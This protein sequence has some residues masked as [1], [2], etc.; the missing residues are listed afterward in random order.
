M[1]VVKVGILDSLKMLNFCRH[2][3]CLMLAILFQVNWVE[4]FR[5]CHSCVVGSFHKVLG[6][7]RETKLTTTDALLW[8]YA[9][10]YFCNSKTPFPSASCWIVLKYWSE[11]NFSI[12]DV[13]W[14][15][16]QNNFTSKRGKGLSK[17][18]SKSYNDVGDGCEELGVKIRENV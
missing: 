9:P 4:F 7:S 11:K 10:P 1:S 18:G 17:V 14:Q 13:W 3:T 6:L 8:L 16:K 2:V 5:P 12:V 15:V